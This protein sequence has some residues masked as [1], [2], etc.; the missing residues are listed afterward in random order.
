MLA[1]I[2]V[3]MWTAKHEKEAVFRRKMSGFRMFLGFRECEARR[4]PWHHRKK[5]LKRIYVMY[6]DS[7]VICASS[8][9]EKKFYFNPDFGIL[10]QSIK[11]ELKVMCVIFT[12]EVGGVLELV[13]D[14]DGTLELRVDHDEGD[15]LYDE[16]G[17]ALK[18]KQLQNEKQKLFED[19]SMFYKLF[20]LGE[21]A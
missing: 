5:S 14:E 3:S 18:I 19:L 8:A 9:Y 6:Q 15:L 12:E 7:V 21:D 17:C 1:Y 11:D 13:F 4:N 2:F 10:P 20:F 16:I